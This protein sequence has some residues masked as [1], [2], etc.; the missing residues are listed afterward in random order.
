MSFFQFCQ[1]FKKGSFITFFSP[2]IVSGLLYLLHVVTIFLQVSLIWTYSSAFL[3]LLWHW[4]FW[5]IQ[6]P[7]LLLKKILFLNRLYFQSSFRF[8]ENWTDSRV[9]MCSFL[10]PSRLLLTFCIMQICYNWWT[11]ND[12]LLLT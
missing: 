1:L 11:N 7:C 5:I 12:T 2:S 6:C 9:P 4:Y 10:Y 8:T 3:C